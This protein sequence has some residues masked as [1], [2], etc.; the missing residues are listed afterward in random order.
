MG[1]ATS[2]IAASKDPSI[3]GLVRSSRAQADFENI[4]G[5]GEGGISI[6]STFTRLTRLFILF[7]PEK[8]LDSP[9]FSLETVIGET[10]T[11]YKPWVPQAVVKGA[12]AIVNRSIRKK[13][14]F[15]LRES[16]DIG[17]VRFF[18]L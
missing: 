17:Q 9:F 13:L 2:I 12:T 7:G 11:S 4:Q 10:V 5:I 3:A 1:A 15:D 6:K 8:V 16:L 18:L 14:G